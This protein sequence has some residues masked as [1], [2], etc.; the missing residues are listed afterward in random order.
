MFRHRVR[1]SSWAYWKYHLSFWY[2]A[3]G[4]FREFV[5]VRHVLSRNRLVCDQGPGVKGV[6]C[7]DGGGPIVFVGTNVG[8]SVGSGVSVGGTDVEVGMLVGPCVD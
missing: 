3:A 7:G 6:A 5:C 2:F 4:L 8:S 1:L